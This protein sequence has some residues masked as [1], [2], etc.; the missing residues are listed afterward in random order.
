MNEEEIINEIEEYIEA[1]DI[2][3]FCYIKAKSIQGLLDLYNKEKNNKIKYCYLENMPKDVELI[4]MCKEDFD[5][6]FGN[7]FINKD[8]IKEIIKDLD[9]YDINFYDN[10][11][12]LKDV[13]KNTLE[14]LLEDNK[15]HIPRID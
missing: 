4:V 14:N 12:M 15:N 9:E 6:N 1:Q 7:N 5:R 8:K 2:K 3:G 10:I 11:Q 13:T